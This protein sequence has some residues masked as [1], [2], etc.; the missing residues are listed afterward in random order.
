[1]IHQK[2]IIKV[3]HELRNIVAQQLQQQYSST[4]HVALNEELVKMLQI[5]P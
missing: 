4:E 1:M 2:L 3:V 5:I